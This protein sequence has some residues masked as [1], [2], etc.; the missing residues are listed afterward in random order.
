MIRI[1]LISEGRKPVAPR[2]PKISAGA[3][4]PASV[5]LVILAVI[6]LL[7]AGTHFFLLGRALSAKEA[8]V[9]EAQREVD[10]LAPIIKEVEEFKARKAELEHKVRVIEDLKARQRGPVRIMDFVSRALPELL[11]LDQM[12]VRESVIR[13]HGKAFNTNAVANFI[14]NLG[15]VEMFEEPVLRDTVERWVGDEQ[16]YEFRIDVNYTFASPPAQTA[17]DEAVSS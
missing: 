17:A 8:E 4:E 5:A 1:N 6:G 14:E 15:H 2:A 13:L 9:A 11:W 3:K 12:E 16:V 10:E 7:V